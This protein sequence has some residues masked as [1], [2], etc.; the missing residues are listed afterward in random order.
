MPSLLFPSQVLLLRRPRRRGCVLVRDWRIE[1]CTSDQRSSSPSSCPGS[2]PSA[3]LNPS[4]AKRRGELPFFSLVDAVLLKMLPV[5]AP[6]QLYFVGHNPEPVSITWNYPDYRAMR[7]HNTVFTGLAGYSRNLE[8][9]GVQTNSAAAAQLSYGI[10]V[11]GNYLD[12]PGVSAYGR[13]FNAADDRAP[14]AAPHK[15]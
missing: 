7:D 4:H 12:V 2:V 14:G 15:R 11:S 9:I 5:K 8:S 13:D 6:A 3:A 10:F 1:G